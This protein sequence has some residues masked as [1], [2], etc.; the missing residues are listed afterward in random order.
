MAVYTEALCRA[1]FA[2]L[3]RMRLDKIRHVHDRENHRQMVERNNAGRSPL[4]HQLQAEVARSRPEVLRQVTR[5]RG[6]FC[7]MT[8]PNG[9]SS[10]AISAGANCRPDVRVRA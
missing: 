10:R 9:S 6:R 1:G 8:V 7:R 4:W 3:T 2:D 5:A